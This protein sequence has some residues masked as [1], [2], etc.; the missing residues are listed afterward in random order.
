MRGGQ[1]TNREGV[2]V[3]EGERDGEREK[4][5]ERKREVLGETDKKDKGERETGEILKER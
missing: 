2:C 5:G 3:C 1:E 4:K